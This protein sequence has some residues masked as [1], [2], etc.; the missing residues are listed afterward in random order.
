MTRTRTLWE[1]GRTPGS[2]VVALAV[3][4][5]LATVLLDL[6]LLDRV[7]LLFDLVFV[8]LCVSVA[9]LVRPRDF[10]VVGVLPPL[11]MLGV[12]LTLATTHRSAIA[13]P[14]DG[15]VQAVVS[16]LSRHSI[17]LG[18]GYALCLAALGLRQRYT[19]G[20]Q[21]GFR[22]SDPGRPLRHAPAAGLLRT[23]RR[24][25]SAPRE[26]RPPR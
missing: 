15:M 3:T 19:E 5:A 16:G 23:S 24:R 12:F 18:L 20:P 10:F 22:R 13:D 8:L 4:V 2:G 26:S 9:L 11:L 17:A 14:A 21:P 7:S 25:W 6:A 1:Q